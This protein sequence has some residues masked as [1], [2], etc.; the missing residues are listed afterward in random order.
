MS[1]AASAPPPAP[2][3]PWRALLAVWLLPAVAD[4]ADGYFGRR[5]AGTP[6]PAW[7]V[8]AAIFPGW[9]VWVLLS[10]AVIRLD[11]RLPL[12]RPVRARV[13]ALHVVCAVLAALLHALVF[14]TGV[15]AFD[16]RRHRPW[17]AQFAMTLE[18]WLPISL[19]LYGMTL[20][21][22]YALRRLRA[23]RAQERRAVELEARLAQAELAVLRAQLD[24]HF[25][26]NALNTAVSLVRAGDGAGGVDVLTRLG[27]LLRHLLHGADQRTTLADELLLLDA[28]LGIERA[29][30][31][32]RLT[33]ELDVGHAPADAL[34]PSLALQTLVENA[35]R[36]G[37]ARRDGPGRVGVVA[38]VEGDAL[39]LRVRDDGPGPAASSPSAAS[40]GGLGLRNVR[41]RLV[42]L[43]GDRASLALGAPPGGGAEAVLRIPLE[44]TARTWAAT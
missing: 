31:G 44:R 7:R 37:V 9:Y 4:V 2:S 39:V 35:M 12:G 14:A 20:G 34:V 10:A 22:A 8:A 28:Y 16:P 3:V 38:R 33:V 1:T 24:P 18:D 41:D 42:R 5:L 26:F 30:F 15:W 43:Y 11:R 32:A 23:S 19:L 21:G 25:L 36:H 13:V 40:G 6:T 17:P 27:E 29:R